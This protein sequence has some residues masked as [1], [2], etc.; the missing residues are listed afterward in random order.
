MLIIILLCYFYIRDDLKLVRLTAKICLHEPRQIRFH[1]IDGFSSEELSQSQ[2]KTRKPYI[3]GVRI[4]YGCRGRDRCRVVDLGIYS[5]VYLFD[6]TTID[7]CLM[8]SGGLHSGRKKV[9]ARYT[10]YMMPMP[11]SYVPVYYRGGY[12]RHECDG[13]VDLRGWC[14]QCFRQGGIWVMPGSTD[15][16]IREHISS[17]QTSNSSVCIHAKQTG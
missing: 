14:V 10:P 3:R 16:I 1:S 2:C 15:C 12:T 8:C 4:P 5:Q 9:M 6:S 11:Y 7:L 13:S 17:N